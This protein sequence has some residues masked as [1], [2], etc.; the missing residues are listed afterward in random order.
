MDFFGH[1][2]KRELESSSLEVTK[3]WKSFSAAS[4]EGASDWVVQS[5]R[6]GVEKHQRQTGGCD[7]ENYMSQWSD[8]KEETRGFVSCGEIK[9][10]LME[11]TLICTLEY[12]GMDTT[13]NHTAAL[14]RALLSNCAQKKLDLKGT[15]ARK[16]N[17]VL[18]MHARCARMN[19]MTHKI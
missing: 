17:I 14:R 7:R 9:W 18:V 8:I 12:A 4:Q 15:Y 1:P 19:N 2:D 10:I 3:S 13:M 16:W 6:W 11:S 5:E